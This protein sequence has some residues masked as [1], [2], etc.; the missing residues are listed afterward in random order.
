M[1]IKSELCEFINIKEYF[2]YMK[3]CSDA[4]EIQGKWIKTI[5]KI[6]IQKG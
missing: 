5:Q 4:Q 6:R 3:L 2:R 1:C